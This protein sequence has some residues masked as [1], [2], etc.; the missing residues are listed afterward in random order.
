R[1]R[2]LPKEKIKLLVSGRGHLPATVEDVLVE[3]AEKWKLERFITEEL[4]EPPF[5]GKRFLLFWSGHGVEAAGHAET[6]VITADSVRK[7]DGTRLFHCLGI[8]HFRTQLQG[9]TFMQ[10]LFCI[11]ACRTPVEWSVSD[12]DEKPDLIQTLEKNLRSGGIRQA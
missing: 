1:R 9:M 6:L 11:N 2:G 5:L 8:D 4:G 12:K 10:Q 7:A 3:P